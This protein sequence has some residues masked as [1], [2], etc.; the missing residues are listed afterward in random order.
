VAGWPHVD[1][2]IPFAGSEEDL[3]AML[4]RMA[5]LD[6]QPG[7]TL[8]V[9]DNRAEP[10]PGERA[11]ATIVDA[12]LRGGSYF[13]RNRGAE[14]GTN[15]WIVFLDADVDPDPSLLE[16]YFAQEPAESCGVL[17]GA[18]VDE[19]PEGEASRAVRWAHDF[20]LMSQ[21]RTLARPEFAYVQ[22]ANAAVRREAFEAIGGFNEDIRSGGDA[23][24]CF[25]LRDAGWELERRPAARVTHRSRTTLRALLRQRARV[26]A[27]ARWLDEHY[28]GFA[29][30]RPL[31]R[32]LGGALKLAARG[33][34]LEGLTDAAF[35]LGWR[36]GNDAGQPRR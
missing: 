28:P 27:G 16:A 17:G 25:R 19:V 3:R 7:D 14:P 5:A 22:T 29:P 32:A 33:R 20:E 23:E 4:E 9:A 12:G 6:L 24:L 31:Y 15:P 11:G 35:Q 2:V 13:A 30:R 21:E 18:V 10:R 26:G 34:A 1:V 8:V 36:L